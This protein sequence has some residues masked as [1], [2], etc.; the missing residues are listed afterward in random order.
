MTDQQT[1][2]GFRAFVQLLVSAVVLCIPLAVAGRLAAQVSC[3]LPQAWP[4]EWRKLSLVATLLLAALVLYA[5]SNRLFA[6]VTR[7][8]W[9]LMQW[10]TDCAREFVRAMGRGRPTDPAK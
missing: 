8:R 7:K 10:T 5:A 3:H 1:K 9:T 6:A 2:G 4:P